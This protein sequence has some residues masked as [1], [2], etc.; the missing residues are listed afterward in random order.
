MPSTKLVKFIDIGIGQK[1]EN[2]VTTLE[3]YKA[4]DIPIPL[5]RRLP[6][7]EM[8]RRMSEAKDD[9]FGKED[10][11]SLL[12]EAARFGAPPVEQYYHAKISKAT[13]YR[14]LHEDPDLRDELEMLQKASVR[15]RA[16]ANMVKIIKKEQKIVEL[17]ENDTHPVDI[18]IS[19][20]YLHRT[21]DEM[22]TTK[23]QVEHSG[24]VANLNVN[25]NADPDIAEATASYNNHLKSI[26]AKKTL[27]RAV[28]DGELPAGALR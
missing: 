12:K 8:S 20:D 2:P 21:D 26:L 14:W 9:A 13:Y 23:T 3:V 16:R 28:E 18:S 17:H 19:L 27:E 24:A 7:D 5:H 4:P 15:I 11:V 6:K 1:P 25:I 22:R 10:K